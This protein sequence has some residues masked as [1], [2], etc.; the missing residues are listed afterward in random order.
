MAHIL[1][2][3]LQV[4]PRNVRWYGALRPAPLVLIITL[5]AGCRTNAGKD[6]RALGTELTA[7]QLARQIRN[8][9][10]APQRS[11]RWGTR[12]HCR[13]CQQCLRPLSPASGHGAAATPRFGIS[14][15][16][17]ATRYHGSVRGA[18]CVTGADGVGARWRRASGCS[19]R[20]RPSGGHGATIL[21]ESPASV[22]A[23]RCRC[24]APSP[25]RH[26]T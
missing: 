25:D 5:L 15:K 22:S 23:W 4:M 8:R 14:A 18:T 19:Q 21:S 13:V 11:W 10:G 3:Q 17:P 1:L 9:D 16:H 6:A 20:C 2:R 26:R 24:P 7:S 12:R